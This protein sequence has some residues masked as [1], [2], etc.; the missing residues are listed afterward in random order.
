MLGEVIYGHTGI[1]AQFEISAV[2]TMYFEP[3]GV[4]FVSDLVDGDDLPA[5]ASCAS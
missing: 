3:D 1:A 5:A 2:G 4:V